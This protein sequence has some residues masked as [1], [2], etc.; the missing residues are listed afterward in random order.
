MFSPS[1]S[2]CSA[3]SKK[4]SSPARP[5]VRPGKRD[6]ALTF[7]S[8]AVPPSFRPAHAS[9]GGAQNAVTGRTV[10]PYCRS[11]RPLGSELQPAPA[12][13][14]SQPVKLLSLL[15]YAC[16]LSPSLRLEYSGRGHQITKSH[17]TTFREGLQAA[18]ADFREYP[19]FSCFPGA[20]VV[21]L[22]QRF[23][24]GR[25]HLSWVGTAVFSS[26]KETPKLFPARSVPFCTFPQS[27]EHD[28]S[29]PRS[30]AVGRFC[31]ARK[32]EKGTHFY[33]QQ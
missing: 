31:F 18:R 6:E 1:H 7:H 17:L 32:Y 28:F 19:H 8:S 14:P 20:G 5:L 15:R 13:K 24:E 23:T 9:L 16:L 10:R 11:G 2:C 4:A 29:A 22:T 25:V 21:D 12:R 26:R 33:P 27:V 3:D 30:F